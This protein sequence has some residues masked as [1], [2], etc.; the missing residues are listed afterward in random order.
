MTFLA[1]PH[2]LYRFP[3]DLSYCLHLLIGLGFGEVDLGGR[4]TA[5]GSVSAM[6]VVEGD[7]APDASPCLRTG[8]L[9]VQVDAFIFQ[10]P[11]ET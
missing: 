10:G 3:A 4:L 8:L 1:T 6:V 5:M 11:P 2:L 9:G 7:P